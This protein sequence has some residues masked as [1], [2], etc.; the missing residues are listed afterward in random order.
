MIRK[1]R[2]D[3]H[4]HSRAGCFHD[5]S[6]HVVERDLGQQLHLNGRRCFYFDSLPKQRRLGTGSKLDN[7]GAELNVITNVIDE[8]GCQFTGMDVELLR[9]KGCSLPGLMPTKQLLT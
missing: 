3:R 5:L 4:V 2:R 1:G 6:R 8:F 7:F 9:L